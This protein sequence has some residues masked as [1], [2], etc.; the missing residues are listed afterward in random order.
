MEAVAADSIPAEMR[1]VERWINWRPVPDPNDPVHVSKKPVDPKTGHVFEKGSDFHKH[2]ERWVT[3]E[4]AVLSGRPL[5]FILGDGFAGL[6]V[7][8]CIITNRMQ[9]WVQRLLSRFPTYTEIS[10]SGTGIKAFMFGTP[11]ASIKKIGGIELYGAGRFFTVT[12]QAIS[13]QP[14]VD[15]SG[16]LQSLYELLKRQDVA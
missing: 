12:G 10:P 4:E 7:D 8:D 2:P 5:G 16:A 1:A 6:D 3:Y 15:C 9:S 14:V 11:P 13:D